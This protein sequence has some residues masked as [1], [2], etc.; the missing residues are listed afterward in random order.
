MPEGI[1]TSLL[2]ISTAV[3]VE[4]WDIVKVENYSDDPRVYLRH[5]GESKASG[6]AN[7]IEG[8]LKDIQAARQ[9]TMPF[10]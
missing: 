2:R 10:V 9:G 6:Y 8:L 4:A 7:N 5:G 1:A 3:W